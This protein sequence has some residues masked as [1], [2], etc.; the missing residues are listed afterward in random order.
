MARA[1]GSC[2]VVGDGAVVELATVW[3]DEAYERSVRFGPCERVTV[4]AEVVA[5]RVPVGGECARAASV[6]CVADVDEALASDA[7]ASLVR[8]RLV[9]L[10]AAT[11]AATKCAEGAARFAAV[12]G[13]GAR[14]DRRP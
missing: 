1:F 2:V 7:Y 6:E 9:G 14:V 8:R 5:G 11:G 3:D 4:G 12:A 13:R 10:H